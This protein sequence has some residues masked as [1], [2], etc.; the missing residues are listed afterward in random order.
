[1]TSSPISEVFLSYNIYHIF[2]LNILEEYALSEI[3]D[4]LL[5]SFMRSDFENWSREIWKKINDSA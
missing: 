2:I 1:M 3:N 4:A 5:W